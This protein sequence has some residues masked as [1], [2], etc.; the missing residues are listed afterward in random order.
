[1]EWMTCAFVLVWNAAAPARYIYWRWMS[2]IVDAVQNYKNQKNKFKYYE[3]ISAFCWS[4]E[5]QYFSHWSACI[6]HVNV[7]HNWKAVSPNARLVTL[8]VC[9]HIN[10]ATFV[11]G[12]VSCV[13][14]YLTKKHYFDLSQD[15]Y[16]T[17]THL[18]NMCLFWGMITMQITLSSRASS[19]KVKLY[20]CT[21]TRF[22]LVAIKHRAP[23]RTVCVFS[24]NYHFI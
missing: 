1:M 6:F 21:R 17:K 16:S 19:S 10:F 24:F 18:S 8:S 4:G 3:C 5:S 9:R 14:I 12:K 13:L 11:I 2:H 20:V 7:I 22:G 15:A 23:S